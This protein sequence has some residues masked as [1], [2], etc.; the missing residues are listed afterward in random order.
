MRGGI[1]GR[2]IFGE[3]LIGAAG[4]ALA[5]PVDQVVLRDRVEPGGPCRRPAGIEPREASQRA[6]PDLLIGVI[7]LRIERPAEAVDHGSVSNKQR[8]NGI[9]VATYGGCDIGCGGIR[10]GHLVRVTRSRRLAVHRGHPPPQ[11]QR[12][13]AHRRGPAVRGRTSRRS[14]ATSTTPT[15]TYSDALGRDIAAEALAAQDRALRAAVAG[16]VAPVAGRAS[17]QEVADLLDA[18]SAGLKHR[19]AD[20]EGYRAELRRLVRVVVACAA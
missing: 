10:P 3:I 14:G 12:R 18:V 19:A 8:T 6:L 16:A 1:T 5:M 9:A 11:R 13:P 4:S 20:V 2:R 15:R 17:P 7:R